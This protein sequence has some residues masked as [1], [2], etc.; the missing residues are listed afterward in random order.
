[1][2]AGTPTMTSNAVPAPPAEAMNKTYPVCS[3]TVTDS[4]RNPGEGGATGATRRHHR[5]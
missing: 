1:M 4:C 2:G 3:R 5:M